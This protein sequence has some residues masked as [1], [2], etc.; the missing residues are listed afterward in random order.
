[1]MG[2][3]ATQPVAEPTIEELGKSYA[4]VAARTWRV[5]L[6]MLAAVVMEVVLIFEVAA[7]IGAAQSTSTSTD[8]WLWVTSWLY[9]PAHVSGL[10]GAGTL[11]EL[12]YGYPPILLWIALFAATAALF[13]VPR[14][15]QW[16]LKKAGTRATWRWSAP[17][18]RRRLR[19][20]L[21]ELGYSKGY[22]FNL[23]QRLLL[24]IGGIASAVVAGT[25]AYA[26]IERSGALISD[27]SSGAGVSDL[28]VGLG[29]TVC[30]IA[31]ALGL[32]AS[33][34]AWPWGK[35]RQVLI[36]ADGGVEPVSGPDPAR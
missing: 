28:S 23:H 8:N 29:P 27:G 13:K 11:V 15:S 18:E 10:G 12:H 2:H 16:A 26:M 31:G 19:T 9:Q 24:V 36:H 25:S 1:M 17:K 32:L 35:P 33:V 34:A 5:V 21:H 4:A 6:V 3:A 14:A 30:L 22:V 20:E 7:S